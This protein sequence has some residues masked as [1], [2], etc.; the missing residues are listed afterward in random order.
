MSDGFVMQ[1]ELDLKSFFS[2]GDLSAFFY[3]LQESDGEEID[4]IARHL[5]DL[6]EINDTISL[7]YTFSLWSLIG[8]INT[9]RFY[10]YRGR[11]TV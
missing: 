2:F 6:D 4:N 9:E 7:S 11:L 8:S 5:L 1:F 3:R 10:T